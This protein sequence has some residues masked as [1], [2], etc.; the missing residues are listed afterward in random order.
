MPI[1]LSAVLGGITLLC[2][3]ALAVWSRHTLQGARTSPDPRRPVTALVVHGPFH[4][5]RNP[6]YLARTLLYLGLALMADAFWTVLMLLP[7]LTAIR[8]GVI[9]REERYLEG[10]FGAAYRQYRRSVRRWL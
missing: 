2:G 3:A 8:Y 6:M 1:E 9:E 4:F 7:L 5:S 10:R